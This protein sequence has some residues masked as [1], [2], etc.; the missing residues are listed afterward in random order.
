[1]HKGTV[2]G[3]PTSRVVKTTGAMVVY[4]TEREDEDPYGGVELPT[5]YQTLWACARKT[6]H[7][8]RV[9]VAQLEE[10]DAV[11]Q[12]SEM[13]AAGGWLIVTQAGLSGPETCSGNCGP[14]QDGFQPREDPLEESI[15]LV[16]VARGFRHDIAAVNR[17]PGEANAPLTRTLVS[18]E[19]AV[20]WL[21]TPERGT[22]SLLEGC[23]ASATRHK[24]ACR[25]ARVA[26]GAIQ[27]GSTTLVGKT[28]SWTL[29][30]Q[31]QSTVL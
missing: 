26:T 2:P 22:T 20:A 5:T 12:M 17:V 7:F 24:L 16:D 15:I 19:G 31:P 11:G 3:I 21:Q 10:F 30:G 9:G 25:P 1:V 27:P 14:S 23:L 13:H 8:V 28:L 6:S 4:E 18:L 29:A